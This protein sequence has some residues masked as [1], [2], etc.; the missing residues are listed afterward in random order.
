MWAS[1]M[2]YFS[3]ASALRTPHRSKIN[4]GPFVTSPSPRSTAASDCP[5]AWP[6]GNTASSAYSSW[7]RGSSFPMY[8]KPARRTASLL[9][10]LSTAA[11]PPWASISLTAPAHALLLLDSPLAART[12][13][14]LPTNAVS[15]ATRPQISRT[16]IA[17]SHKCSPGGSSAA[18][19]RTF[20]ASAGISVSMTTLSLGPTIS[21]N[22]VV[23]STH[24]PVPLNFSTTAASHTSSATTRHFSSSCDTILLT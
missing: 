24:M 14:Q 6:S 7:A 12:E 21:G 3:D 17:A 2:R 10:S 15:I 8:L 4:I 11:P 5:K 16:F 18:P 23:T 9:A 19:R 1:C 20:S 13:L 22:R